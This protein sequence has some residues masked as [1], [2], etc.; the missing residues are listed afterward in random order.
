LPYT[1]IQHT[2][3]F[4]TSYLHTLHTYSTKQ[5]SFQA[6]DIPSMLTSIPTFPLTC[7]MTWRTLVTS[8]SFTTFLRHLAS[9]SPPT[10]PSTASPALQ[11]QLLSFF[12]HHLI[13][14]RLE[15]CH[16]SV[17]WNQ[18]IPHHIHTAYT[19][20]AYTA[21]SN[22]VPSLPW[23]LLPRHTALARK[24]HVYGLI[25]WVGSRSRYSLLEDQIRIFSSQYMG[26]DR[27]KHALNVKHFQQV[28]HGQ[29]LEKE[30]YGEEGIEDVLAGWIASEDIYAC[31]ENTT[32][33]RQGSRYHRHMPSTWMKYTTIGWA[34]AQRRPVRSL[35][36]ILML[37]HSKY[38]LLGDDDTF[39]N[40][41]ILQSAS[42]RHFINSQFVFSNVIYGTTGG[43]S[44]LTKKGF[45]YG[46]GGYLFG[47]KVIQE[48]VTY[49]LPGPKQHSS[50][51]SSQQQ[52]NDLAML[53]PISIL[54]KQYCSPEHLCVQTIATN[55]SSSDVTII[56]DLFTAKKPKDLTEEV[57][58]AAN[59]STLV[60]V[61]SGGVGYDGRLS[62]RLIDLCTNYMSDEFTCYHSDHALSRCFSYGLF[63][64]PVNVACAGQEI[65]PRSEL[66]F[67]MCFDPHACSKEKHL[68]CHRWKANPMDVTEPIPT[69]LKVVH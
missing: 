68:T 62:L 37:Y 52:M 26:K 56:E 48:L 4:L 8:P 12:F 38:I 41:Q 30:G 7:S 24:R 67:G 28:H 49:T 22:H 29:Q 16:E 21:A 51:I 46:G 9:T 43:G 3:T 19:P 59:K 20:T 17:Q 31:R 34:C 60:E 55:Q 25:V 47:E 65:S 1:T 63:A 6:T 69:G 13:T 50:Q 54:A 18:Q 10:T 44:H 36:H 57:T 64:E 58:A 14:R 33:P 11:S 40:L 23:L 2:I 32:C 39:V 15:E 66:H 45:F 5:N 53:Y 42:F 61:W 35:A 27:H